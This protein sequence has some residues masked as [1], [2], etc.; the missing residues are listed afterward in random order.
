[1]ED[2]GSGNGG[3]CGGGGG[4]GG[5]EGSRATRDDDSEGSATGG[6]GHAE[7]ESVRR[8]RRVVSRARLT[9]SAETPQHH[10]QLHHHH[11][12]EM[13]SRS[14]QHLCAKVSKT[15]H[16]DGPISKASRLLR[17]KIPQSGHLMLPK[18][19]WMQTVPTQDCEVVVV[20]APG[21][22][23]TTLH[24]LL[25]RL[26]ARLPEL[27]VCVKNHAAT[28]SY[29]L[30]LSATYDGLIKGG[31]E[32]RLVK[33]MKAEYGG[34]LREL[35]QHELAIFQGV[36]DGGT[37][38]TTLERQSI[39]LHILHSLRATHEES[40]E[41][42]SFREG[43]AII[44]KFQSDGTIHGILPLHD[45]KKL[46]VLR[47]TWVQTFFKYQPIEAIEQYFGSK[48]AIYFAWLGHYTT[49]LTIP[50]VIGLIF[51]VFL[52][53]RDQALEDKGFVIFA[54]LNVV[55][56][57][58]WLEAWKRRSAELAYYWGTLDSQEETLS[59]PRPHFT[60]ELKVSSVTGRL[61]PE[62]PAW[63]R[64]LI[65]YLVT[66]PLICVS[67]L[68][69]FI[70]ML[71]ILQLQDLCDAFISAHDYSFYLSY[72][73]KILM[74]LTISAFD[75]GYTKVAVWLND[76]ENYRVEDAYQ[77]H[78]ITKLAVFRFVNSF[79]SLFYIAFYLQDMER[80]KEQLA[81]LLLT[82][83]VVGN[84][85][86]SCIPYLLEQ[87]KLAKLSFDLYGALS[88]SEEKQQDWPQENPPQPAGDSQIQEE[89]DDK[90]E[91]PTGTKEDV[92][93]EE[94]SP[95]AAE[96]QGVTAETYLP[97]GSSKNRIV[98]QA[99]VECNMSRYDGTF[100]DY[101]EMFIQFGYVTLFS[102]AFPLA[103][104]CAF[105]NN[106][107]EIRSD[108]FKL[109]CVFQRPFGHRAQSI[110]VWQDAM[111]L[112]GVLGIMV[113][114]MLIGLSGQV[115]RMFPEMSTVHT[116]LLIIVLEHAMIALKY[117]I[118]YA[119]PDIPDWVATEMAKVEF[120]RREA[121]R[122]LSSSNSPPTREDS[123]PPSPRYL[124][125]HSLTS[126]EY[127]DRSAQTDIMYCRR[128][129]SKASP[130]ETI[131]EDEVLSSI[132]VENE[133][134]V[135]QTESSSEARSGV[136][137][138]E[139]RETEMKY[140]EVE[141]FEGAKARPIVKLGRSISACERVRHRTA[142]INR[143]MNQE[144][145]ESNDSEEDLIA[146]PFDSLPLLSAPASLDNK[147]RLF[148]FSPDN[149]RITG[150]VK[151]RSRLLEKPEYGYN[152]LTARSAECV[153][154]PSSVLRYSDD[155]KGHISEEGEATPDNSMNN[156]RTP[157]P[158]SEDRKEP[159]TPMTPVEATPS[160]AKEDAKL[161]GLQRKKP[162]MKFLKRAQSLSYVFKR[163]GKPDKP[164]KRK[165]IIRD[166]YAA[167]PTTIEPQGELALVPL[168]KLVAIDDIQMQPSL[169]SYNVYTE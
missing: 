146:K 136:D 54:F 11:L 58:T 100:E 61:E 42:T 109:C 4:G 130:A 41:A 86:E 106:L 115:H 34:G 79:L 47:T 117:G 151:V 101:L 85:K 20:M 157:T 12:H 40:I 19:M 120:Q 90:D 32:M 3:G 143:I 21:T 2:C 78:L 148:R 153:S 140:R 67:L 149:E 29:A 164:E 119:I 147:N 14:P 159:T 57:S 116:I 33:R 39:V 63:K 139:K 62:Y 35:S 156:S 71:L 134:R 161:P 45:Y 169:S 137:L 43:Q 97:R 145:A 24:W 64:N 27:T 93:T 46:E 38:F 122:R 144:S 83:Q 91:S 124:F 125:G 128:R 31:E 51:W 154:N 28:N 17:K 150:Q 160:P 165:K 37:F 15:L 70:V 5:T 152:Q 65:R 8:R 103:A 123:Q 132:D 22:R 84:I 52:W 23:E 127:V 113:N 89:D 82:R 155:S 77:N 166:D 75:E 56:A 25:A 10:H 9:L 66:L 163:T 49:A 55:W 30:Y 167:L 110:G 99:E 135:M 114:C 129:S 73:P 96:G 13:I 162:P 18:R 87:F 158:S 168:E 7:A 44:P 80:L 81:A 102:S 131:D 36:E 142:R 26:K 107:I 53:G 59:E 50:A 48:I 126:T 104:M 16:L 92:S 108:A 112:M 121:L 133:A 98:S 118:S 74:A 68:V 138:D 88:P 1:M 105:L 60:G 6:T 94:A 111:E 141:S 72:A 69:V 76:L 95:S